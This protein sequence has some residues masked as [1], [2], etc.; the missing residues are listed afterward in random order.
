MLSKT[1]AAPLLAAML[2]AS[3]WLQPGTARQPLPP[4]TSPAT[5]VAK[6]DE[7]AAL[8]DIFP[9]EKERNAM[10]LA[11]LGAEEQG[12]LARAICE[13][14]APSRAI[15]AQQSALRREAVAYLTQQ[16]WEEDPMRQMRDE[17]WEEVEVIG[18]ATLRGDRFNLDREVLVARDFGRR[19]YYGSGF[20]DELSRFDKG[21]LRSG[22][23][24][25]QNMGRYL[26]L[27]G[28]DG[29]KIELRKVDVS[30]YP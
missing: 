22:V 16:G 28:I 15:E 21:N 18:V 29:A 6:G 20:R 27:I 7:P 30:D 11:K 9:D 26:T 3:A 13:Y 23:H 8:N 24:W 2:G 25:G 14:A 19:K 10:G 1:L 4:G 12:H 17:G 5:P